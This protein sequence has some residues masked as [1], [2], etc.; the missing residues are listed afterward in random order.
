MNESYLVYAVLIS[1][2]L[3]IIYWIQKHCR[4][5]MDEEKRRFAELLQKLDSHNK[6]L[7]DQIKKILHSNL[8]FH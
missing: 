5:V 4:E 8:A 7:R 6:K 3:L 2:Q 1:V